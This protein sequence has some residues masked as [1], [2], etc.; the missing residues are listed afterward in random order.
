[1]L[2]GALISVWVVAALAGWTSARVDKIDD[3]VRRIE[4]ELEDGKR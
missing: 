2:I 3:R 1:M 4:K